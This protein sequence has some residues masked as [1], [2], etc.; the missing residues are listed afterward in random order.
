MLDALAVLAEVD[1]VTTTRAAVQALQRRLGLAA[2]GEI[3]PALLQRAQAAAQAVHAEAHARAAAAAETAAAL[4]SQIAGDREREIEAVRARH[5]GRPTSLTEEEVGASR[6][7]EGRSAL[8][9]A[10]HWRRAALS[11]ERAAQ[12]EVDAPLHS[13]VRDAH[14]SATDSSQTAGADNEDG[15]G[16]SDSLQEAKARGEGRQATARGADPSDSRPEAKA[17]GEDGHGASDSRP[18][19][20]ARGE[21]GGGASDSRQEARARGEDGGGASDSRQ[22]A[23]ARGEDGG[24]ASDSRQEAKARGE[25]GQATERRADPS[26]SRQ[27][28]RAR[29]E[30][31]RGASDSRQEAKDRGEGGQATG[32]REGASDSQQHADA[33]PADRARLPGGA[34]AASSLPTVGAKPHLGEAAATGPPASSRRRCSRRGRGRGRGGPRRRLV[35]GSGRRQPVTSPPAIACRGRARS[36]GRSRPRRWSPRPPRR[37][38][39][40]L[41][42]MSLKTCPK[43]QNEARAPL[44]RRRRRRAR[45]RAAGL[46]R[47]REQPSATV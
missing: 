30:D 38:R 3:T 11:R 44:S 25:G 18:E 16:A 23:R 14:V 45:A 15:R 5:P 21:D 8:E 40:G 17:R 37:P 10:N 31:G 22:E 33:G 6:L 12:A 27:E 28:A 35:L 24:G 32:R 34:A 26:D 13:G 36:R 41:R 43:N 39:H 47:P 29:G 19:A 2:T 4:Y 1:D 46:Q 7:A 42:A 20:R 9:A